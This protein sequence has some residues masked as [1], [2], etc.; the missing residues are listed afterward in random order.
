MAEFDVH[1]RSLVIPILG[2]IAV[3]I[4]AAC[5]SFGPAV[6]VA[7][8]PTAIAQPAA[9]SADVNPLDANAV[10]AAAK[11]QGREV[12]WGG[13]SNCTCHEYV[14]TGSV[15]TAIDNAKLGATIQEASETGSSV[16]FYVTFDPK[17]ATRDRVVAA[18]K[19][20]GGRIKSGPPTSNDD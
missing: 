16:Y 17:V 15:A 12:V 10:E 7:P 2:A 11:A 3:A 20:G 6:R 9:S 4:L 14:G 8:A 1:I 19:A 13:V 18:I 5:Q